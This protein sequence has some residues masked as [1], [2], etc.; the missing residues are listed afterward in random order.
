MKKIFLTAIGLLALAPLLSAQVIKLSDG[1]FA[2]PDRPDSE[3]VISAEAE[4]DIYYAPAAGGAVHITTG[5][6]AIFYSPLNEFGGEYKIAASFTLFDTKGRDREAFGVFFGGKN[7]DQQNQKYAY[8]LLR[9]TGEYLIKT[10]DGDETASV[11]DWTPAPGMNLYTPD[12]PAGARNL[13]GVEAAGGKIIFRLNGKEITQIPASEINTAGIYGL[14][15]N[16]SIDVEA[17]W[18]EKAQ[19]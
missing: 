12:T 1:T 11:Q 19:N 10:R 14:R 16:H 15:I 6:A 2:R 7:L 4:A 3:L 13:L 18:V 5:P 8:F 17:G 9:N